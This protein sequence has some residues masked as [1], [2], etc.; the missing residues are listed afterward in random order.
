MRVLLKIPMGSSFGYGQ[1]GLGLSSALLRSGVDL[2]IRPTACEPP[3]PPE[4]A[5]LLTKELDPPYD[6]TIHHL[7]P[8]LLCAREDPEGNYGL[9]VGWTMWEA[10]NFKNLPPSVEATLRTR[11][12]KYDLMLAYDHV[13]KVALEEYYDGPVRVLQGGFDP[14]LWPLLTSRDW[15]SETF[16]ICM[17][18][19]LTVRKDP[20]V[21]LKVFRELQEEH[22]GFR[23]SARLTLKT[24]S[25]GLHPAIERDYPNV[26]IIRDKWTQRQ[27]LEFYGTQHMLLAPSR[28]EGKNLP[29]L[30]F[31][32]TGGVVAATNWGGMAEWLTGVYDYPL[33]YTLAPTD[34]QYPETFD[35]RVD[36]ESLKEAIMCAFDDRKDARRMGILA[37]GHVVAHKSWDMVAQRMLDEVEDFLSSKNEGN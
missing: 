28:G 3:I 14:A 26:R 37:A 12:E 11:L 27:M 9:Q 7:S 6:L 31:Q 23:K 20:F 17:V 22:P 15:H 16:N 30:E 24:T 10:S 19:A 5:S 29:A 18:G 35:A 33:S 25:P 8:D 21:V 1:D 4:I 2:H 13:T 34:I 36:E 32:A